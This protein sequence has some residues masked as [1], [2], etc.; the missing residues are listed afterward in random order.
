MEELS[1]TRDS[2]TMFVVNR[3][4]PRTWMDTYVGKLINLGSG[5]AILFL[6]KMLGLFSFSV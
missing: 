1:F 5:V 2:E 6:M 3:G 4:I